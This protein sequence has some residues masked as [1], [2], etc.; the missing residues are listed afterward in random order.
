M[1]P[2]ALSLFRRSVI[3]TAIATMLLP[4]SSWALPLTLSTAPASKSYK[5]PA[6]NVIVSVDNSGS[7]SGQPILDLKEALRQTFLASNVPDGSIRLAWQAMHDCKTIPSD[8]NSCN[9]NNEM[10]VL[11]AAHRAN[12]MFW[13]DAMKSGSGTPS[14][15]MMRSAGEYLKKQDL[16]VKSPWAS[17]PGS[18]L[19]PVL[20]CRRSYNLFMTDGEWN[21]TALGAGD[22]DSRTQTLGD[23]STIYDAASPNTRIYRDGDGPVAKTLSDLAFL[24]WATDLQPG[25]NGIPN[26]VPPR[27]RER[28]SKTYTSGGQSQTIPPYWN[29]R[30]DPATWQHM[31]TYT[32]GFRDAAN[33]ATSIKPKFGSDTW[34]GGDYDDLMLGKEKWPDPM[35][36]GPHQS[37]RRMTELWHMAINS[38][39]KFI[40]AP[41]AQSLVT[42]FKDI[43]NEIIADNTA[44][45]TSLASSATSLRRAS[46]VYSAAFDAANWT[47]T[48]T[49]YPVAAGSGD[50][51]TEGAW[52]TIPASTAADGST[53]PARPVTTAD[54]MNDPTF[55]VGNR[56]VLSAQDTGA[57]LIGID[58]KWVSLSPLKQTQLKTNGSAVDARG[59]ERLDFIR[60]DRSLEGTTPPPVGGVAS[61]AFRS[62]GS[63]LGDI[64][65]SE[66]WFAPGIPDTPYL[67]N[68]YA[69]FRS[70]N[71]ERKSMIYVGANDGMLHGFDAADGKEKIAYIPDGL[72]AKLG[73]LSNVNYSHRYYVDGSPFTADIYNGTAWRTFLAGFPGLGGK[74]YFV[75]DVTDP[76]AFGTTSAAQTVVLD[77]TNT[78][79]PDIGQIVSQPV[80]DQTN[81]KLALQLTRMNNG[82]WAFVTGNGINST[83]EK[84][85][86][87]I[88]YVDGAKELVKLTADNVPDNGNGLSAPRLID[89]N[90]DRI[91]DVA[92]AGD[93]RGNLW[94]FDLTDSS[95]ANWKV[96]FSGTPLY[97]AKDSLGNRQPITTT[98]GWLFHPNNG[99]MIAVGTGRNVTDGD[100]VDGS[101]QTLYGIY[102][103]TT[104]S[105]SATANSATQSSTI[106]LETTNN[107]VT[108][109]R[110]SLVE[111]TISSASTATTTTSADLWTVSKNS[112]SYTGAGAKRGWFIDLPVTNERA[113]KS[114]SWVRGRLFAIPTGVPA[115]GGNPNVEVCSS[116]TSAGSSFLTIVNIINGRPPSQ[117]V[118]NYSRPPTDST[119]VPSRVRDSTDGNSIYLRSVDGSGNLKCGSPGAIC[120]DLVGAPSTQLRPNWRQAQ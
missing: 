86:L 107:A 60:G 87:L 110:A 76:S 68:D 32:V 91:P 59:S 73:W 98:P 109:A 13:V 79:D 34:T 115:A 27:I 106:E 4:T 6:P 12:F 49:A 30:N 58:W 70:S 63:R 64:V 104:W 10:K 113:F 51:S 82:R 42:A 90:G 62:R 84:A 111:Q 22:E 47:G 45:M 31:T 102:D 83:S 41:N 35:S 44:P 21:Q 78:L 67:Q 25:A 23:D 18:T 93:L 33:W 89:I 118:F 55:S 61:N 112:V 88:Q 50:V 114:M 53:I 69:T 8:H 96:A 66:V 72:H 1:K 5:L 43:L 65:N 26:Q 52:G 94:K 77:A 101:K 7:M 46:A 3:H 54:V 97:V 20:A 100:R 120:P 105:S 14:H 81:P 11:N 56:V 28:D 38:R 2:A 75:L 17:V 74:G 9:K 36:G 71:S 95:A 29:P 80:L 16:G 57:G 108:D 48:V 92:Y 85:V 19:E 24:Y 119:T 117:P 37:D 39:G 116:T 40:P 15:Q 99:L 103:P